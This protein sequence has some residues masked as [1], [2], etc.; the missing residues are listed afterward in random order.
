[1]SDINGRIGAIL[2][3]SHSWM[4]PFV[5]D[6]LHKASTGL[7]EAV[8]TG[9]GRAVLFYGRCSMGESLMSDMARDAHSYS[10]ELV[11]GWEN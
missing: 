2:P 3:P 8:V 11:H 1:M 7:I 5:E 6:M 4:A 9:P 10:Q